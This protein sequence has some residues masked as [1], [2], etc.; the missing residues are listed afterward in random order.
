MLTGKL[1]NYC[2]RLTLTVITLATVPGAYAIENK[3]LVIGEAYDLKSDEF[4]YREVYCANSNPHEMEV[5]YRNAEDRVLA[6][7][8]LDYSSG[9]TTPSFV[10]QNFYSSEIIEVDLKAGNVTMSVLDANNSEPKKTSSAQTDGSLPVVIDAGFDQFI[11]ENWDGLLAGEKKPFLFPFVERDSLVELRI[12][13]SACSYS[14][15]THQCFK[16]ELSNWFVRML[17]SPIELGYDP[18]MQRLMRYRGLSNIGDG[19]G[20]GSIVDIRY[21]YG[22][23]PE[24]ACRLGEQAL[25]AS[26]EQKGYKS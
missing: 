15:E 12:R 6:R 18:E 14:S 13:K 11:R 16:L 4:L 7:K 19:K 26:V 10:Q 20:N 23:V 1:T 2:R 3:G 5:I 9:S 8:L 25:T 24:P 21:D 22:Q 17:V